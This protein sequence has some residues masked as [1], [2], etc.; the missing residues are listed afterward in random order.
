MKVYLIGL[1]ALAVGVLIVVRLLRGRVPPEPNAASTEPRDSAAAR[2]ASDVRG[3]TITLDI[4]GKPS[5][6]VLLGA[7]GSINR[8]GT[9]T[10]ENKESELF[11]GLTDPAI[12]EPVRSHLTDAMLQATIGQ[13]FQDQHQRGRPCKL[14]LTF[15]FKDG[16]SNGFVFLYGSESEGPPREVADFVRLA[17]QQTDPWYEDFKRGVAKHKNS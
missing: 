9:G 1:V 3:F 5:L 6:F 15:Q 14:T 7:D 10:L 2:K 11:I 17:V 12:F 13:T 4:D 16:T 8:L